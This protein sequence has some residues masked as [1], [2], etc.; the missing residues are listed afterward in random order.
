MLTIYT[1]GS[2]HPNP[3]GPGGWAAIVLDHSGAHYATL[4]GS[5][6]AT[7]NNRMELA[8]G[9]AALSYAYETG[10]GE[11][12]ILTD[13]EYLRCSM[14]QWAWAWER[15]GWKKPTKNRDLLLPMHDLR[16]NLRVTWRWVRGH[17]GNRWNELA[18]REAERAR[19]QQVRNAFK[20]PSLPDPARPS[21]G[22]RQ[23]ELL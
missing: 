8:A 23:P 13:S 7:T 17:A 11:A 4:L 3:G 9:L 2:C 15:K 22:Y 1:D 10:H 21:G 19:V 5:E 12:T 20:L 18:D 14:D 6:Q 16:K